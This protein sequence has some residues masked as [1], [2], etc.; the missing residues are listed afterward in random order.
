MEILIFKKSDLI[1][2]KKE[3]LSDFESLL[4]KTVQ[5]RKQNQWVTE[6]EACK[7]LDVS[8]STIQNY[9]K[10]GVLP[11]SQYG[12]KIK[13]KS[14]DLQAFLERNYINNYLNNSKYEC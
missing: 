4:S 7:I 14:L 11:F 2:F 10:K 5:E 6:D 13:Y 9:R 3:L 1:Q 8:K 12:S